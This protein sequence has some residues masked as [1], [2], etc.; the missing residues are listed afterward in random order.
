M[1]IYGLQKLSLLDYPEKIAATMF[2][3]GCNFLCPFCHNKDLVIGV[4]KISEI[5]QEDIFLFL[6]K[7]KGI[8]E[9]ICI[10]GGEPLIHKDIEEFIKKIR[11]MGY[12]IKLDTN[13]S[14][15]I[16]L[17][18]LIVKNLIDYV[19]MDI[20][21]SPTKYPLT[22]G[23]NQID[24]RKIKESASIIMSSNIQYEFRTTVIKELHN[25]KDFEEISQWLDGAK[26]Y[27]LQSYLDS[28][29]VIERR[30][31]AHDNCQ[32]EKFKEILSKKIS[33]VKIR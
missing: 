18:N 5:C 11:K 2:T 21:N 23:K 31:K 12:L 1:K 25:S 10:S 27:F 8:L 4:D 9:G 7:R 17:K 6:E 16:E 26:K 3:G 33:M 29:N 15:P 30:F 24:I 28:E 13:G 32:M 19:A 20:K 22:C 14:F